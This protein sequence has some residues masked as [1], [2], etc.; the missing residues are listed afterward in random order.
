M[1]PQW[2]L[3]TLGRL[4]WAQHAL[5]V[6]LLGKP[7]LSADFAKVLLRLDKIEQKA[8]RAYK[9]LGARC[10]TMNRSAR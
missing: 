9:F 6:V 8:N 1:W 7:G 2:F 10:A 5:C 4:F 3:G